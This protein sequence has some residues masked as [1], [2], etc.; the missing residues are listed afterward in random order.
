MFFGL[1]FLPSSESGPRNMTFYTVKLID[2]VNVWPAE[3]KMSTG[4]Q[5][6]ASVV[7]IPG[8]NDGMMGSPY[9]QWRCSVTMKR[10]GTEAKVRYFSSDLYLTPNYSNLDN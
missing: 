8:E 9:G 6:P 4:L 5:S 10:K 7:V 2:G 3:G 1:L